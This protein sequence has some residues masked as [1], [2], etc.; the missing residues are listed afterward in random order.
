[1]VRLREHRISNIDVE[2][3]QLSEVSEG[4]RKES[5]QLREHLGSLLGSLQPLLSSLQGAAQLARELEIVDPN[6]QTL[7]A[8]WDDRVKFTVGC[9]VVHH[10]CE[11]TLCW[12]CLRRLLPV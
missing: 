3:A 10:P 11:L 9:C 8:L 7:D 4:R 2:I 1:M 5:E 12:R 6:K